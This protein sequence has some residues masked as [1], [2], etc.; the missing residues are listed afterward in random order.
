MQA[1]ISKLEP[2]ESGYRVAQVV[3]D[4]K[5]FPV[6]DDLYWVSC[7]NDLEADAKWFD[8]ESNTFKDFP[9]VEIPIIDQKVS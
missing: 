4:D 7:P 2:R 8:E 3:A 9:I 6:A 1:L 5:T